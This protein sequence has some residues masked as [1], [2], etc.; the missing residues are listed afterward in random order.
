[1]ERKDPQK[2]CYDRSLGL[3]KKKGRCRERESEKERK[4]CTLYA[5]V[6]SA[7]VANETVLIIYCREGKKEMIVSRKLMI[8]SWHAKVTDIAL[9]QTP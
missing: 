1:M 9:F 6:S 5:A 2:T 8:S 7:R 3:R 4:Y